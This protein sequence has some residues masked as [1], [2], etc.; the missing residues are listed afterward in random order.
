MPRFETE[1]ITLS[2]FL[3]QGKF[4]LIEHCNSQQAMITLQGMAERR[5]SN[6]YNY[7]CLKKVLFLFT[8]ITMTAIPKSNIDLLS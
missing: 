3:K 5:F 1:V 7:Q 6:V 4:L 2:M 8:W